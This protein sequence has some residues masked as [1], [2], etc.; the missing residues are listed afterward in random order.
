MSQDVDVRLYYARQW[1]RHRVKDAVEQRYGLCQDV[2]I[3]SVGKPRLLVRFA[4]E[5]SDRPIALEPVPDG[6]FISP[7]HPQARYRPLTERDR[8]YLATLDRKRNDL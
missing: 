8:E 7:V 3:D 1:I 5:D 2:E 4:G 6:E